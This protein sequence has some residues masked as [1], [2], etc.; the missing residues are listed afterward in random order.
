MPR[1]RV[2]KKAAYVPPPKRSASK[3]VSPPWVGPAMVVLFLLGLAWLI[4]YYFSGGVAPAPVGGW[5]LLIGFGFIIA[6]FGLSTQW[7]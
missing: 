1:S 5:N 3:K 2:R 7:R 4:V 6:G